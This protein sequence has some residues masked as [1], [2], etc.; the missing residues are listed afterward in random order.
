MCI[1]QINCTLIL[2]VWNLGEHKKE[3]FVFLE[4]WE[5]ISIKKKAIRIARVLRWYCLFV[6]FSSFVILFVFGNLLADD[7][8]VYFECKLCR[9]KIRAV[10]AIHCD[11]VFCVRNLQYSFKID[12]LL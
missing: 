9:R 12:W 4:N 1:L 6:F 8:H 5:N 3:I 7:C 10:N 2:G 11:S